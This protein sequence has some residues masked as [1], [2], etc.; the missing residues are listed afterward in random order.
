MEE[1]CSAIGASLI[2]KVVPLIEGVTSGYS[3]S[4]KLGISLIE[5]L[6]L[7]EIILPP[8][9]GVLHLFKRHAIA[10][11]GSASVL[12]LDWKVASLI[13]RR[14]LVKGELIVADPLW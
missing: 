12:K 6:L 11:A 2:N 1:K 10:F 14:P 13:N 3:G 9:R 4:A 7:A 8:I 5:V